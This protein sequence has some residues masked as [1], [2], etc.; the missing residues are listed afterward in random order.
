VAV[1][2]GD[3]LAAQQEA[4]AD[5]GDQGDAP[6]GGCSAG[7]AGLT[8]LPDGTVLPCRR[9]PLPLGN[10]C[11]DSLREIWALHPVLQALRDRRGYAA[12]C[13]ACPRWAVCR[14]CRAVAYAWSQAAG[15]P[16]PLAADPQ[17]FHDFQL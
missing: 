14:G 2:S 7:V 13:R 6:L 4:P 1:I 5:A 15:D 11:R 10:A 16:D 17:C 9:L 3:P 12:A 8:L